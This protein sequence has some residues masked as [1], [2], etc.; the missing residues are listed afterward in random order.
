[1]DWV[2]H[3]LSEELKYNLEIQ[4]RTFTIACFA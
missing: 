3:E 1:M 2:P 4:I